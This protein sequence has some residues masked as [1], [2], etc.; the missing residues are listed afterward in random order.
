MLFL[1]LFWHWLFGQIAGFRIPH[2]ICCVFSDFLAKGLFRPIAF[3]FDTV[4]PVNFTGSKICEEK[5]WVAKN[6]TS[7]T[8]HL[9]PCDQMQ[10]HVQQSC[11]KGREEN[12]KNVY[13]YLF[14]NCENKNSW[15]FLLDNFE[16]KREVWT[17]EINWS[18][19]MKNK[20]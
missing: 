17:R 16:E 4:V 1:H 9:W 12:T 6:S 7:W 10:S 2:R 14:L 18:Y 8:F 19:I 20:N 11:G 5:Q 15:I 13:S 3:N